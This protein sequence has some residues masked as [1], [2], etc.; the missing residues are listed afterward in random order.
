M[1]CLVLVCDIQKPDIFTY[2]FSFVLVSFFRLQISMNE[3]VPETHKLMCETEKL[4]FVNEVY[5]GKFHSFEES[6]R[7]IF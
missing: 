7:P 4:K 1:V 3:F 6:C 2:V 5:K